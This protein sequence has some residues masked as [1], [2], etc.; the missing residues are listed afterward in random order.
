MME[1]EENRNDYILLL[2]N[3]RGNLTYSKGQ[4]EKLR[5]EGQVAHSPSFLV[6]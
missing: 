3:M 4:V 2:N 5:L 1:V 6:A